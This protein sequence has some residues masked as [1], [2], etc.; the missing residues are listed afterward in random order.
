MM[1]MEEDADAMNW[2]DRKFARES[3]L[4]KGAPEIWNDVRAAIQDACESYNERYTA[5]EERRVNCQIENGKRV[6]VT[7]TLRRIISP[8]S[9]RDEAMVIVVSLLA[10]PYR[11]SA[12]GDPLGQLDQKIS[13][14]ESS[15]FLEGR[16]GNRIEADE[17]SRWILELLLFPSGDYRDMR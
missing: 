1:S 8:S 2:V 17:L 5:T 7:K 11:I 10:D 16:T 14:D 3:T 4:A 9:Y 13:A 6:R 15:V 12:V